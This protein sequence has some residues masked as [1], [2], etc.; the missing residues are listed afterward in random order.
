MKGAGDILQDWFR[1]KDLKR[2]VH[3]QKAT[4]KSRSITKGV[5]DAKGKEE[6][7]AVKGSDEVM[8]L[9]TETEETEETKEKEEEET[10][11]MEETEVKLNAPDRTSPNQQCRSI[12]DLEE[13][14]DPFS[15]TTEERQLVRRH[16]QACMS[17]AGKGELAS[18]C[19]QYQELVEQIRRLRDKRKVQ[20]L[21]SRQIIGATT[22]GAAGLVHC[23][24]SARPAVLICEEAAEILESHILSSLTDSVQQ[25]VLVGDH[26]QL[27]PKC[28][29]YEFQTE[30]N[31]NWNLDLSMFN[32]AT[33]FPWCNCRRN[34][35]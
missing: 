6:M 25:L 12:A 4:K 18:L 5:E 27:R 13:E 17:N 35:A 19:S 14:E 15:L 30:S 9:E 3:L 31:R 29:V 11:E 1:G 28:E 24:K 33:R 8:E 20:V 34:I 10:E 32:C 22:T 16:L 26:F 23:F 7:N 2:T 21:K